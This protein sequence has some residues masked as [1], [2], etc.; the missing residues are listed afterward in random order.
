[1]TATKPIA[2]V[3]FLGGEGSG[4]STLIG[5]F[6]HLLQPNTQ[7]FEKYDKET[8]EKGLP[9]RKFA[10]LASHLPEERSQGHTINVSS[11]SLETESVSFTLFD[12]PGRRKW[13]GNMYA[14]TSCADI[15]VLVV[16]AKRG[17]FEV[18]AGVFGPCKE[19]L[20][21]AFTAGVKQLVVAINQIDACSPTWAADRYE[22]M[23]TELTV[24]FKRVGYN[25]TNV[26][27]VPISAWHGWNLI[28]PFGDWL[29][30]SGPTL[31]QALGS[32]QPQK[33]S[34]DKPLR[35]TVLE[36]YK[37][38]GVG[39]VAVGKVQ[40]GGMPAGSI[41]A[42]A[43]GNIVC[44]GNLIER[45]YVTLEKAEAGALVGINLR[46]TTYRAIKRG[47]VISS[48]DDKA[49]TCFRFTAQ[50][51]V[52]FHPREI[53]PGYRA[54]LHCHTAKS[55]CKMTVLKARID[56]RTGR[57][58]EENPNSVKTGDALFCVLQLEK[59]ICVERFVD[60]PSLGRFVLREMGVTVAVGI[61]KEVEKES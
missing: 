60:Y 22:E 17:Q 45:N 35:V 29:W 40:T 51:I 59:G 23:T 14:G 61:I 39:T 53:R 33:R 10:W 56:R 57:M 16:S 30:Y 13:T 26:S 41:V 37:I 4:K 2:N 55:P 12:V 49:Q 7:Q 24:Y 32:F 8:T 48:K 18:E 19:H 54:M 38:G 5:H 50:V 21:M 31:L 1:M 15:A 6:L 46:G 11:H 20:L 58:M 9:D 36:G 42:V 52:L 25:G 34:W 27:I 28:E 44:T 3:V 43:P 47:S